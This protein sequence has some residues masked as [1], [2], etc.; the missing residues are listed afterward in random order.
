LFQ[1]PKRHSFVAL[2]TLFA[3]FYFQLIKSAM[4]VNILTREDLEE[5]KQELLKELIEIIN[6][7]TTVKP[8]LRSYEVRKMLNISTATLMALRIKGILP[9]CRMGGSLFY[10]YE[11]V[12]K[13]LENGYR[14]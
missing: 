14:Q 4:A 1:N 6:P 11:D 5:F 9:Y 10:K 2:F 7:E 3:S 8:W 12:L 13:A